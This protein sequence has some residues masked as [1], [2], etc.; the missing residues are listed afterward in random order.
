MKFFV[1]TIT[2]LGLQ[3][4]LIGCQTHSGHIRVKNGEN[5]S[6]I[7][8]RY[9]MSW[10]EL[11]RYNRLRNPHRLRK[12]Q[13]L[14]VPSGRRYQGGASAPTVAESTS[15]NH[16]EHRQGVIWPTKGWISSGFGKRHGRQHAG[17]D[18]AAPGGTRIYAVQYGV[19]EFSG[20][21]RGYGRTVVV[22]HRNYKTLYAHCSR[23]F[24]RKGHKVSKGQRI[25]N[26]GATGNA[27]GYHL[28]FEYRTLAGTPRDP[29]LLLPGRG[30]LSLK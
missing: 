30:M 17:I 1:R 22:R 16:R 8:A 18:I 7:A 28:H 11:A 2:C 26:V 27:R 15:H 14:K 25:A 9:G 5:L 23:V 4:M 10:Q 12:G 21:M 6:V 20:W 29:M 13:V 3:L 19:V 24:V